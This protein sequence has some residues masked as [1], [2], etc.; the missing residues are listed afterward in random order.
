MGVGACPRGDGAGLLGERSPLRRLHCYVTGP[1][2]LGA[3]LY[4]VLSAFGLVVF[5]PDLFLIVV[6]VVSCLAQCAEIP[7]GKYRKRA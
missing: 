1:L 6:L 5:H 3:A 2:Y 4:V 7:L